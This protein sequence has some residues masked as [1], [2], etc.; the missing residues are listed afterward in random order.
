MGLRIAVIGIGRNGHCF[1]EHYGR[2]SLVSEVVIIDPLTGLLER[3]ASLPKVVSSYES[4]E[5]FFARDGADVVSIHTPSS[6]HA[7]FF[8]QAAVRGCH[9][10]VEKPLAESLDD[11]QL[12]VDAA[13]ANSGRQMAVG[14]NY[15]L[16]DYSPDVKQLIRDGQ[17]GNLICIRAGYIADYIYQWLSEP[18]GLFT[19]PRSFV[20]KRRAMLDGACHHIDLANYFT[21]S[22][23][24]RVYAARNRFP[25]NGH[26]NDWIA[27]IFTYANGTMLHLD[28]CWGAVIPHKPWFGIEVYGEKGSVRDGTLY[29]HRSLTYG[30]DPYNVIPLDAPELHGHLFGLEVDMFLRAI[31]E[32]HPVAV[33]VA[34]GANAA[35]AAIVA[36]DAAET[37]RV[38][39]IPHFV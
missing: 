34:E 26:L 11:L 7:G 23:P 24:V 32:K 6:L 37:G 33:T 21:G 10:F 17:L 28:A 39:E 35:A 9:I 36:T 16:E 1:V 22:Y 19:D 12:M 3:Y 5:E 14:H 8:A 27:S 29:R 15:R 20:C 4:A 25:V 13:H 18:A 30:Q 31:V 2:S 38:M